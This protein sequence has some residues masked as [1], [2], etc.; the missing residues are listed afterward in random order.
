VTADS[1]FRRLWVAR[2]VRPR[3][4]SRD[5]GVPAAFLERLYFG[6]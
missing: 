4:F 2:F 3:E 1:P 6:R 5:R